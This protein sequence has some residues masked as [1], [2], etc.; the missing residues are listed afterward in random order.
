MGL[1]ALVSIRSFNEIT[2]LVV[3]RTRTPVQLGQARIFSGAARR[4]RTFQ[5]RRRNRWWIRLKLAAF[6]RERL[7]KHHG[8]PVA[9]LVLYLDAMIQVEVALAD[10]LANHRPRFLDCMLVGSVEVVQLHPFL[11]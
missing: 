11:V 3:R 5:C 8:R 9:G 6:E 1:V 4:G 2:S 7:P 10:G